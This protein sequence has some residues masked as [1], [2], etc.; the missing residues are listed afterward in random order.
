MNNA[1][2]LSD[3]TGQSEAAAA[4]VISACSE[5]M[6]AIDDED[7]SEAYEDAAYNALVAC[8]FEERNDIEPLFLSGVSVDALIRA[9]LEHPAHYVIVAAWAHR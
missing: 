1:E 3:L 9:L 7:S 8:Y 2:K 4:A 6:A 5:Y